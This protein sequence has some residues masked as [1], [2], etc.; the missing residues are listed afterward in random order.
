MTAERIT[1]LQCPDAVV[2]TSKG[3]QNDAGASL[4]CSFPM[5]HHVF[6]AVSC[7]QWGKGREKVVI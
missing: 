1:L 3:P 4:G 7:E 5:E 2:L 6:A